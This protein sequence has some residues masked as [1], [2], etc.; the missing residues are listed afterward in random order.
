LLID[1][2]TTAAQVVN[3]LILVGL[4]KYFLYDKVIEAMDRR[5]ESI[6]ESYDRAEEEKKKAE[7][8]REKSEK[9][10]R[11][12][13]N[14]RQ[15]KLEQA[16]READKRRDELVKKAEQE[17]EH[18]KSK[19]ADSL[20]REKDSFKKNL[21]MM[22]AEEVVEVSRLTLK[23]LA[24]TEMQES[25]TGVFLKKLNALEEDEKEEL[26]RAAQSGSAK[27]ISSYPVPD[28]Q[29]EKIGNAFEKYGLPLG[30]IEYEVDDEMIAGIEARVDGHKIAWSVE[31]YLQRLEERAENAIKEKVT[32]V[33]EGS[34]NKDD[35]GR[36]AEDRDE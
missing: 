19:W 27:I 16:E 25:L 23:D 5:E 4:L 34:G 20:E 8:E 1:W 31:D 21:S 6:K 18:R 13:E 32:A 10:R 2:F 28:D 22:V 30:N 26:Q 11:D 35:A 15:E 9:M 12:L 3:F 7:D 14:K 33:N 36:E 17:V 29:R 24:D